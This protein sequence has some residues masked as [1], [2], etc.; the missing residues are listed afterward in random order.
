MNNRRARLRLHLRRSASSQAA[1]QDPFLP[2]FFLFPL[3]DTVTDQGG[4]FV[5][6][7]CG[8]GCCS[9]CNWNAASLGGLRGGRLATCQY[10]FRVCRIQISL[11]RL[12]ARSHSELVWKALPT[13]RQFSV[14][15]PNRR[16]MFTK[17][18][19]SSRGAYFLS[20]QSAWRR[21][22]NS[23]LCVKYLMCRKLYI[24]WKVLRFAT[25]AQ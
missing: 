12:E 15:S 18:P 1:P 2:V 10:E 8:S 19:F 25:Y 9:G 6:S 3:Q 17:A 11:Q 21:Y 13:R 20:M 14:S 24:I 23:H 22:G 7:R 16:L 4:V 5:Q